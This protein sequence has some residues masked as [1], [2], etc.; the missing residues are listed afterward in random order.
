M[1]SILAAVAPAVVMWQESRENPLLFCYLIGW[2]TYLCSRS[3][4]VA[5]IPGA[6]RRE[7]H[8]SNT[9]DTCST[10]FTT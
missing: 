6:V 10:R 8:C 4:V 2:G 7:V 1:I 9:S 3:R 5:P